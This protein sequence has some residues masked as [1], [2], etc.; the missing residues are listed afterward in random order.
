M[1][2]PPQFLKGIFMFGKWELVEE[3]VEKILV[4]SNMYSFRTS[5]KTVYVDI[6]RKKKLNGIYKYKTVI[7]E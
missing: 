5:H 3:N 4:I 7:R 6:Y 1:P 2:P